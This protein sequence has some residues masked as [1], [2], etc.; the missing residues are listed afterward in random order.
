MKKI[1]ISDIIITE[2]F[3]NSHPSEEK[4]QKYRREFSETGKQ[5][6]FLVVNNNI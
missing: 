4:I 3:A 2:A 5:S 1:R 6:K